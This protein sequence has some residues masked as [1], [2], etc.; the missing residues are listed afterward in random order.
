MVFEQ[1]E[2]IKY[3][4][5][6]LFILSIA[7]ILICIAKSRFQE[8]FVGDV[9][10]VPLGGHSNDN[11]IQ[12]VQELNKNPYRYPQQIYSAGL[13]YY[14]YFNKPCKGGDCGVFGYCKDGICNQEMSEKTVFGIKT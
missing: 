7:I 8:L 3:K 2:K 11:N 13:P 1:N 14:P 10:Q 4:F 5:I 9:P 12:L 6:N